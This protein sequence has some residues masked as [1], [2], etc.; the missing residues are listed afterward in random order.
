M[1]LANLLKPNDYQVYINAPFTASNFYSPIAT[2]T[3]TPVQ[4][5]D[6][7]LVVATSGVTLTLPSIAVLQAYFGTTY[8]NQISFKIINT[9][10]SST[11]AFNVS[12]MTN[13]QVIPA[14]SSGVITLAA[15]S[16]YTFTIINTGQNLFTL[17]N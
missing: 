17:T 13:A 4:L 11:V 14:P 15:S 3:L 2:S 5:N 7:I 6:G 8:G 10:A 1:S 12:T 16:S 9:G